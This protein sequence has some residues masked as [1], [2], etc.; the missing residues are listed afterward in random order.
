[1]ILIRVAERRSVKLDGRIRWEECEPYECY[2]STEKW[3]TCGWTYSTEEDARAKYDLITPPCSE[4]PA[5]PLYPKRARIAD[6][7]AQKRISL[8]RSI[9]QSGSRTKR[10]CVRFAR[11]SQEAI[12]CCFLAA[13]TDTNQALPSRE[14]RE[15]SYRLRL[16]AD[17]SICRISALRWR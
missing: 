5:L 12:H 10:G 1:M 3:G 4:P 11:K 6:G 14:N 13:R 8:A 7:I 17:R 2:P 9:K 16:G 15:R